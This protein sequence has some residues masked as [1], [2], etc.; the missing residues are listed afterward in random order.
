[1]FGRRV[2]EKSSECRGR[3]TAQAPL[4]ERLPA[5]CADPLTSARA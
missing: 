3:K 1:M 5:G 4:L 2:E